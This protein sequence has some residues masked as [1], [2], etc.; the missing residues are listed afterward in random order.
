M[1]STTAG[2]ALLRPGNPSGLLAPLDLSAV[3]ANFGSPLQVT[4][5]ATSTIAGDGTLSTIGGSLKVSSTPTQ[6]SFSALFL[7]GGLSIFGG[8]PS[9]T[10][11]GSN[12]PG[13][14]NGDFINLQ[15]SSSVRFRVSKEGLTTMYGTSSLPLGGA[16][17]AAAGNCTSTPVIV[18]LGLSTSTDSVIVTPALYPGDGAEWNRGTID[19]TNAA[20][21]SV[22]VRVCAVV[23]VTPASTRYNVVILRSNNN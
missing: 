21:S 2:A 11:I 15:S 20:T 13:P 16:L 10:V 12:L 19:I 22:T 14:F 18:P 7:L 3:P 9:G 4:G 1:L 23:A 6:A 8:S 5:S 17:L